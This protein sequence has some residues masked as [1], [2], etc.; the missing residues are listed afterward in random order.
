MGAPYVHAELSAKRFGGKPEDYLPIHELMDS[1]KQAFSDLRH[2]V[3]THHPWFVNTIVERIFGPT[4]TL[5]TGKKVPTRDIAQWHVMEDFD[6]SYPSVQDYLLNVKFQ[7]WMDNG[8]DGAVPP[9]HEGLPPFDKTKLV[10]Q[11]NPPQ[12]EEPKEERGPGKAFQFESDEIS[13]RGCGG[14]GR[15]D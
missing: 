13:G 1:S 15:L 12:S 8:K 2:R 11:G 14:G 10:P 6:G 3:L 5:S 4:I 9:S 7:P